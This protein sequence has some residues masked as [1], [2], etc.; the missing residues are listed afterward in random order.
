MYYQHS[1]ESCCA[2]PSI[3]KPKSKYPFFFHSLFP[4]E[5]SRYQKQNNYSI[6]TLFKSELESKNLRYTR[7]DL[8]P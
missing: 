1:P 6:L 8:T 2:T 3:S 5:S 4:W 7:I